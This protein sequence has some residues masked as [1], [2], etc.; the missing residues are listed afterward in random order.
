METVQ[1]KINSNSSL[2]EG[3][4]CWEYYHFLIDFAP[5]L[6]KYTH[7]MEKVL[8]YV[9][10]L[11]DNK[12]ELTYGNRTMEHMFNDVFESKITIIPVS[13]DELSKLDIPSIPFNKKK[14]QWSTNTEDIYK[15]FQKYLYSKFNISSPSKKN[16]V[17]I[18]RGIQ[19]GCTKTGVARR[20]LPDEFFN[21]A[22]YYFTKKKIEFKIVILDNMSLDEQINIFY[23]AS[24]VLGIH[25]GGFSNILFCQPGTVIFE[26]GKILFPCYI[27]LSNKMGLIHIKNRSHNF[28]DLIEQIETIEN[29]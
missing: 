27:N 18:R 21:D 28:N 25:G 20:K 3:G 5:I 6:Y 7:Q 24:M 9:P 12:F 26:V 29:I 8:L 13:N 1:L 11:R 19:K 17:I 14:N 2:S 10:K 22:E 4:K 16:V 15:L 23:N